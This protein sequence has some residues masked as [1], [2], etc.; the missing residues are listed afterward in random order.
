MTISFAST[1]TGCFA[2]VNLKSRFYTTHEEGWANLPHLLE[3]VM[4]GTVTAQLHFLP[5]S[6]T[7]GPVAHVDLRAN[8][9]GFGNLHSADVVVMNAHE[10]ADA[11]LHSSGFELLRSPSAVSDFYDCD[12]VMGTY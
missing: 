8:A 3:T 7:G 10:H 1:V 2:R 12:E 6:L 9:D 11:G 4:T 5:S